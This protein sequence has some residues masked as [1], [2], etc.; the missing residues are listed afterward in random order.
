VCLVREGRPAPAVVWMGAA[1]AERLHRNISPRCGF[2]L[3]VKIY[4]M[5]PLRSRFS[6]PSLSH[7]SPVSSSGR[8]S[9]VG[10]GGGDPRR[11]AVVA[12]GGGK[13]LLRRPLLRICIA[14]AGGARARDN[15]WCAGKWSRAELAGERAMEL[16]P[17]AANLAGGR[18]LGR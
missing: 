3:S 12:Q 14:T 10:L 9:G 6:P 7:L 13:K 15:G 18:S 17:T 11:R 4:G 8:D 5:E 2:T 1:G 16:V